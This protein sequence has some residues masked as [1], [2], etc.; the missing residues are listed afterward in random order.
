VQEV[1]VDGGELVEQHLVQVLHD[2]GIALHRSPPGM[3]DST[4]NV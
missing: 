2:L 3:C 4:P 1:L